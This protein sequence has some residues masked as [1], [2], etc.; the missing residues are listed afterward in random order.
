[1][2]FLANKLD[3]DEMY[4]SINQT[5]SHLFAPNNFEE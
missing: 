5:I 1:M 3:D 2:L 4:Q